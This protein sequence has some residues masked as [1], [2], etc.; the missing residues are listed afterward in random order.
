MASYPCQRKAFDDFLRLAK[1]NQRALIYLLNTKSDTR[2]KYFKIA[3]STLSRWKWGVIKNLDSEKIVAIA[4]VLSEKLNKIKL[5]NKT[6]TWEK[7]FEK[8]TGS[9][10]KNELKNV[11]DKN[12]TAL[13][14]PSHKKDR[15]I[16][17]ID[18]SAYSLNEIINSKRESNFEE[19]RGIPIGKLLV[20]PMEKD[21]EHL[22]FSK[23]YFVVGP[24]NVGKTCWV[25]R[26]ALHW[27]KLKSQTGK[28]DVF[29]IN[30]GQD[31]SNVMRDLVKDISS[32]VPIL[33]IIDDIHFAHGKYDIWVKQIRKIYDSRMSAK[34]FLVWIGRDADIR[35]SLGFKKGKGFPEKPEVR[36][37]GVDRVLDLLRKRLSILPE[38][39]QGI[40][41]LET[42]L[43]PTIVRDI[44]IRLDDDSDFTQISNF[45]MKVNNWMRDYTIKRLSD[46]E[47]YL[48]KSAYELYKALLPT[49]CLNY[50]LPKSFIQELGI[51]EITLE[52]KLITKGLAKR[53]QTGEIILTEH[54]FQAWQNLK[55][56]DE[57][58]VSEQ[59]KKWFTEN[60]GLSNA[61]VNSSTVVLGGYITTASD[62][63]KTLD[64]LVNH[65]LWSG[66]LHPIVNTLRIMLKQNSWNIEDSIKETVRIHYHNLNRRILPE[67]ETENEFRNALK[68]DQEYWK[69][70]QKTAEI[71]GELIVGSERLDRILYEIGYIEY[72]F[73]N[74]EAAADMFARSVDAA[75]KIIDKGLNL[76]Q[77]DNIL[78]HSHN[79]LARFWVSAI[80]EKAAALRCLI[81]HSL[82][83]NKTDLKI[84]NEMTRLINEAALIWEGLFNAN[85]QSKE[86]AIPHYF[87]LIQL[88]RPNWEP[89]KYKGQF[90]RTEEM[91]DWFA[92]HERNAYSHAIEMAC[93]P[94][95]FGV[96]DKSVDVVL[97]DLKN[98]TPGIVIRFEKQ[99]FPNY[100]LKGT[101]I[102]YR[103]NKNNN[104]SELF[105]EILSVVA[106]RQAGG[107]YEYVGDL[108][109]LAWQCASSKDLAN[110]IKWYLE[111]RI[112]D[113]GFNGLSKKAIETL[114]KRG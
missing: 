83:I 84:L 44:D 106:L 42:K 38:W 49:C 64:D 73:E 70:L 109:L 9:S 16:I 62:V 24:P 91:E 48:K 81:K 12:E 25:I 87:N 90:F 93:W 69:R 68:D 85:S 61:K 88:I 40:M 41:A 10:F 96:T 71:S 57:D 75:L 107:E 98:Y 26:Q 103:W 94:R 4:E 18:K 3:E 79:A 86:N 89:P 55:L 78:E 8:I 47:E 63:R 66:V 95:L 34:T 19:V 92:R 102:L 108:L 11:S 97:P 60:I 101:D 111:N 20:E 114:E 59:L 36:Y 29:L 23:P 21:E 82:K 50:I 74:Y 113:V 77:S 51:N 58:S 99:V 65:A 7:V 14:Q 46:T 54:P 104:S 37:Y 39:K 35:E 53:L 56:I 1:I 112:P 15:D 43:D 110:L 80:L 2:K 72:L 28:A 100:R 45:A 30:V 5:E 13:K 27:L 105:N 6:L 32:K 52:E 67:K 76:K 33:F 22:D 17:Q 31:N